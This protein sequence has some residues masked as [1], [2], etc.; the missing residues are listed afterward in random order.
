[1]VFVLF[2]RQRVYHLNRDRVMAPHV[3]LGTK[4][5]HVYFLS[6]Y[7]VFN[8]RT[9]LAAANVLV[10]IDRFALPIELRATIRLAVE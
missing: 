5:A 8:G 9:F 10:E 3:E 1:M 7:Y 4:L 2:L 6:L